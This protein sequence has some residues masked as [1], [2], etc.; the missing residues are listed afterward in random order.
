MSHLQMNDTKTE[1]ITFGTPHLLSKKDLDSITAGGTTV[2]C[3]NTVK[4][5]GAFLD[6]TLSFKQHVAAW[7]K[8]ALWDTPHQKCKKI[9]CNSHHKMLMCTFVLS[10]LDCINSIL[11]NTSLT[12]TKPYKKSRTKL[13]KL[14]TKRL[15]GPV[16]H[17]VWNSF[18]GYQSDTRVTLNFSQLS[19]KLCLE[20]DQYT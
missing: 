2:S 5:L 3:S 7:A 12:T 17:L 15:N 4:F 9:S 11:T 16:Q 20:W 19:I 8:L 1:F 13:P 6:E 18:T 10:Q 14:S